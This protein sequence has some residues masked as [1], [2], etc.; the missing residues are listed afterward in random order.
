MR[1]SGK[2]FAVV[3]FASISVLAESKN[4]ADYPLRVH[5]YPHQKVHFYNGTTEEESKGEGIAN[6][7]ENGMPHGVEFTFDCSQNVKGNSGFETY[8]AKWKKPN[9]ELVV[10]VPV[11]AKTNAYFTCNFKTSVKDEVYALN[12]GK[13]IKVPGVQYKDW[14]TKH[15]YDP[16]HGLNTPTNIQ[17]GKEDSGAPA[18]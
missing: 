13:L 12:K 11:F 7:Y 5:V 10:L 4:P 14:M 18:N 9:Q 15:N 6:L 1:F 17:Q 16:E 3:L 8:P 2:L